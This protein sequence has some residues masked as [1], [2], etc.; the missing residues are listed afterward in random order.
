MKSIID[1]KLQDKLSHAMFRPKGDIQITNKII[2]HIPSIDE[3]YDIGFDK[4]MY[5]IGLMTSVGMDL[6]LILDELGED[7]STIDDFQLFCKYIAPIVDKEC[8]DLLFPGLN[9]ESSG[10]ILDENGECLALVSDDNELIMN[11]EIYDVIMFCLRFTHKRKRNNIIVRGNA[12]K[13]AYLEDAYYDSLANNTDDDGV[14][15]F[16][17]LISTM[18][19]D[20]GFSYNYDTV[21]N[22]KI[23]HFLDAV[24]RSKQIHNANLLLSSGQSGFGVDLKKINQKELNRFAPLEI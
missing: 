7:F 16:E 13:E 1:K 10:Y 17:D 8:V 22:M 14:P 3:V 2:Y 11:R 18:V 19:N 6:P 4:Y 9:L 21:Y 5:I 24:Y 20:P 23:I 12:A 15:S